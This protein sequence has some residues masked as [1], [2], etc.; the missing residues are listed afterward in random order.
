MNFVP[1]AHSCLLFTPVGFEGTHCLPKSPK[2]TVVPPARSHRND[3]DFRHN[4][5][6]PLHIH[7]TLNIT[8]CRDVVRKELFQRGSNVW[9]LTCSSLGLDFAILATH[10]FCGLKP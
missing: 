2:L 1:V 10:L 8:M 5:N 4:R 6:P 7:P 3:S 9:Y